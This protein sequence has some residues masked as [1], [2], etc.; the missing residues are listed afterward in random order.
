MIQRRRLSALLF[1][2]LL[3]T[4]AVAQ[5]QVPDAQT[6]TASPG[7]VEEQTRLPDAPISALPP[8]EVRQPEAQGAPA[9]AENITFTLN[10][11]QIDGVT[12]YT[13]AA[14]Q[15]VYADKIGQTISLAD[16]YGIAAQLTN[17]YRNDGY[18]L[19]QVVVPPQTIE[20]GTAK[21][22][23]VEGY[24]YSVNVALEENAR[25]EPENAMNL[26]RAYAGRISTGYA[27]NIKDLERYLLLINDLPGVSAR[28][29]LSPSKTH[30]GA[31]DL[32]ILVQRDPFEALLA[33]DNYGTKYLGAIQFSGAA[34]ANSTFGNNERLTGQAVIAPDPGQPIELAYFAASYMQPLLTKG[35]KLDINTSHT[36]TEPGYTLDEF[37]VKGKATFFGIGLN[38]PLIRSRATSLYTT[39][40]FDLRNVDTRNNI[41]DTRK[42][43]IRAVRGGV[44]LE[45]LD[46]V[47]GAGLNVL[48][49]ELAQGLDIMG[50][51]S[52]GDLNKSRPD[53]DP[54]FSKLNVEA[55]RLQRLAN[56]WN[57]LLAVRGQLSNGALLSSEEF[58]VGGMGYGR[59]YDPSE[60]IGDEG[61]AG[62]IEVQWNVPGE[63][64]FTHDN[65]IFGFADV[66]RVWN[67]DPT[68]NAQK[69]DT[70]SS[71]GVGVR[72][73][74]LDATNMDMTVALP[75]NRDVQVMGDQDPRFFMSVSQKF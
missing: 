69:S 30:M 56:Q 43:R 62:K 25:A 39:F 14:L 26:I 61:I 53:G 34:S 15:K 59:G 20:G 51:S 60:I 6:G 41:E 22:Q 72:A 75:L 52:D 35:L 33:A 28:G 65:Q 36:I 70:A 38:Y 67:D 2:A 31:A 29:V 64:L 23:V 5:A 74:I 42:D 16:L 57:M 7:R 21:L 47:F 58:G 44:R 9:G 18:I 50:A 24:I 68:S 8:V 46:G 55:Q 12:A 49:I 13:N 73:K 10:A 4:S 45:H 3:T 32:N 54:T 17:K 48:D 11:L 63:F 27:L 66:G 40:T 1:A 71:V 19:T 37:D